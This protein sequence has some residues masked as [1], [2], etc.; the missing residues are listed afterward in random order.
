MVMVRPR[1]GSFVYSEREIG[2][3]LEEIDALKAEESVRGYVF[4]CLLQDGRVDV[5]LTRRYV[6][7]CALSTTP[8]AL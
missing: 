3:M 7:S 2:T 6:H 1:L 8:T 5:T 4:G